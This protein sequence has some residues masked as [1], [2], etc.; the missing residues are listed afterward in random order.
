MENINFEQSKFLA[1]LTCELAKTCSEKEVYFAKTF[2]LTPAEFKCLREFG[3]QS[4]IPV[5]ELCR[6]LQL[7]PGRITHIL[8]NLEDKSFLFRKADPV[9][10]RNV[11]VYLTKKKR[12]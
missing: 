9:D 11:T 7:T 12:F 3:D 2:N 1:E 8:T 10:K 6:R 4:E 5:K